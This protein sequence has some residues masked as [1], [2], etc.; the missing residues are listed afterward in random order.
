MKTLKTGDHTIKMVWT[1]GTATTTIKVI[2]KDTV[3]TG[4]TTDIASIVSLMLISM[5][6][7]YLSLRNRK[8]N[9]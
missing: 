6:G 3:Q 8:L 2:D 1:D 4:D 5:A 9:N 7:M